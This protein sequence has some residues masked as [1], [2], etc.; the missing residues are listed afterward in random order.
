MC[1]CVCVRGG[2]GGGGGG[3][4]HNCTL[5]KAVHSADQSALIT[6]FLFAFIFQLY[7][8]GLSW[9][10]RGLHCKLLSMV[11]DEFSCHI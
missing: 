6:E 2:G 4:E 8:D 9:H 7:R 5:P 11:K 10:L 1:V 3:G